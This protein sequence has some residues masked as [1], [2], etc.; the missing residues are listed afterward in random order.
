M[1]L[2]AA[3]GLSSST[4]FQPIYPYLYRRLDITTNTS[5]YANKNGV[6]QPQPIPPW[7]MLRLLA[8]IPSISSTA[9]T[10]IAILH[11]PP[12]PPIQSQLPIFQYL[13]SLLHLLPYSHINSLSHSHLCSS[14]C[15]S[16]IAPP[17]LTLN[18]LLLAVFAVNSL[19]YHQHRAEEHFIEIFN[20]SCHYSRG[21]GQFRWLQF[22]GRQRKW[23]RTTDDQTHLPRLWTGLFTGL[24]R[25]LRIFWRTSNEPP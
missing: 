17:C 16:H 10:N 2:R 23:F 3:Q 8:A 15:T 18:N 1:N 12:P 9:A 20:A 21:N 13:G 5:P 4:T 7:P 19:A 24:H 25:T 6:S 14:D 11:L 22:N